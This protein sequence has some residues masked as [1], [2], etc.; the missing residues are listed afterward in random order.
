VETL[1]K[2]PSLTV[3]RIFSIEKLTDNLLQESIPLTYTPRRFVR[4]PEQPYF[5]TIEADNNILSPATKTKLLEDP[6]VVN[7]DATVL[8]PEEFGYP[9][10]RGHWA[11]CISVIDPVTEKSVLQKID[12]EDNEAA[13]SIATVSFASQ[14]D[15]VFL[16]VGT[17][18]DMVV[19]PR[20]S[21][22]GF[23]HVY[24]FHENGKEIEFIHKTKVEEPPMALL[25]FQGRLL[26]GVGKDLRIYDLGMRQL[27]RK[28]QAEVVPNLIVGLQT[29]G[30]RIV[31]SD[32]Q[33]SIFMIVY[34]FQ[35]NKLIPFV[36]DTVARWTSCT[37][38][39][40]YETIA[41]GDKFGNL[42][43]LR[44]PPKASEEA[45]EEGSG[46]HLVHERSYLQGA[47]HR[48]NLMA[49]F[50]P[51]DIPMAIQKTN[52]VA[53]GRDCLLWAGL[54]GTL[55][56]LIPFVS[57]EDVDFFQT[58]EQHLRSEDAPLAG[59]DH[60]IYRSYYV[61][62]KGVI[63]GDLC[64]RYTLL[65]TDKKQMIAGELDRSVREIERKISVSP[66]YALRSSILHANKHLGHSD[67]VCILN[68]VWRCLGF[69]YVYITW[70][71]VS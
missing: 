51:Q 8:P 31:V 41:G 10:G 47:P 19:S 57:R 39:V 61:P 55:G 23:I 46:Q 63:D 6:A 1:Q 48:L 2:I 67:S 71:N 25:G 60:L 59:R 34:K 32:V 3:I 69:V 38:M 42:W 68:G 53:G 64:E 22:A 14:D 66:P 33:Q 27:L 49:H 58:L 20:T 65:P 15:E 12:L 35:E 44:C 28:A 18:K 56:I 37:T 52:L 70:G 4:H 30:S 21:T 11:S 36:D 26:A 43:L 9:R 24:R 7:G 40:D 29:Q 5:Y 16:V 13:V 54:Q 62:V 17:G 50:F 45:D